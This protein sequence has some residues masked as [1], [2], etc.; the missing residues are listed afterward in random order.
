[1]N[2]REGWR[3]QLGRNGERETKWERGG[4][5]PTI[6]ESPTRRR[7]TEAGHAKIQGE[8]TVRGNRGGIKKTPVDERFEG[9]YCDSIRAAGCLL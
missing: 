6:A 4:T 8:G 2:K 9:F 1:M 7:E 3:R 5:R